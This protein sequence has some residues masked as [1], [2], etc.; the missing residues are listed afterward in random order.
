MKNLLIKIGKN[1]RKAFANQLETK[2]KDKVLK[3]YYQLIKKIKN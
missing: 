1:S 3:N 2:K